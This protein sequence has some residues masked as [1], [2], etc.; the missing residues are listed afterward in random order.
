MTP[1]PF[2]S[3]FAMAVKDCVPAD[4]TLAEVGATEIV[5]PVI[6][7]VVEPVEAELVMEAAVM[8][9]VKLPAGGLAGAL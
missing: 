8:V 3:S 5:I 7:S 2:G 4:F 1:P 6:V 9:T